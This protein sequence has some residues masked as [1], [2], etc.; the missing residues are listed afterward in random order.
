M[1]VYS[2]IAALVVPL[3]FTSPVM[4]AGGG[5][6]TAPKPTKTTKDCF[7]VRVWD[8]TKQRCV[9]PKKSSLDD[10][11]LYEAVRE[12][13]Y[14]GR[15]QDSEG[16][17]DAMSNQLDDRVLTYRGFN[18]RKQGKLELANMFYQQAIAANPNNILA[19]SYMAQGFVAA[20]DK[21]AA[22][23]Q[24][25]EIQARGG[26]GTWAET[27]LRRAIEDGTTYNY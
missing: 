16:V 25:R 24:L 9:R 12:L 13:A 21:V 5:N 23:Q 15:Y 11:G 26:T 3:A 4:A 17:L 10:D 20:G 2:L 8:E 27:S 22:M 18:A 14:A 19:R 1:R 7:G 6:D